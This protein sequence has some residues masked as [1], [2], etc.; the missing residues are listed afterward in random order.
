[1]NVFLTL[2]SNTVYILELIYLS[3]FASSYMEDWY[4]FIHYVLEHTLLRIWDFPSWHILKVL[5]TLRPGVLL[6]NDVSMPAVN[7]SQSAVALCWDG[8]T[9]ADIRSIPMLWEEVKR[10]VLGKNWVEENRTWNSQENVFINTAGL[11]DCA[12]DLV[13]RDLTLILLFG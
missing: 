5:L 7:Y 10:T 6:V 13:H 1:M 12:P 4:Y 11:V 8:A 9:Y 3:S 2:E